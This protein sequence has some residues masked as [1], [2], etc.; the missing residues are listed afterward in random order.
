MHVLL[1]GAF[2]N[3]GQNTLDELLRLGQQVRCF[4]LPS[5]T[6]LRAARRHAGQVE[7]AW[8]DLRR[9]EDVAAAVRDQEAVI[10]LAFITPKLSSTGIES[11]SRPDWAHAINVGG[12]RNLIEALQAQPKP[13]RIVFASSMAVYGHTQHLPPPRL[14]TD[15]VCP[16]DHYTRHK[17]ECE[18]AVRESG[19]PW[20]VL[21]LPATMPLAIH[22][23]PGM[24][25][26]PLDNRIEFGHTRDIGVALAR[27]ASNEGVLGKTLLLGGGPRCQFTYREMVSPLLEAMGVGML[28]EAAFTREPF[29]TDWLDSRES[30]SLL[31]YQTRGLDDYAREMAALLGPRRVLIRCFRPLARAW[32]LQQ[33]PYWKQ[34][35]QRNAKSRRRTV[36]GNERVR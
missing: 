20:V 23:D 24:F 3:I 16:L 36:S 27:A 4:D 18:Q 29:C 17:V 15:P 11:E 26:V 14:A 21:R 30:E 5:K 33:S 2:G 25:D 9:P 32:V 31:H 22:L 6:N 13:V 19:L 8:G 34:R 12:T 10:H 28:P 35:T 7:L 1:T